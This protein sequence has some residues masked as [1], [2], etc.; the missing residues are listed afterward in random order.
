MKRLNLRFQQNLRLRILAQALYR[1]VIGPELRAMNQIQLLRILRQEVRRIDGSVSA[2]HDSDHLVLIHV[3]VAKLAVVNASVGILGFLRQRKLAPVHARSDDDGVGFIDALRRLNDLRR[4]LQAHALDRVEFIDDSAEI[5]RLLLHG[6][7]QILPRHLHEARIIL[8][9]RRIGDLSAHDAVFQYE[10]RQVHA[11]C[12]ECRRQTCDA[13]ADDDD[14]FMDS[15]F[16]HSMPL[17]SHVLS[18]QL[19][20]H[21][22]LYTKNIFFQ[23]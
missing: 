18:Q 13:C 5:L 4:R 11:P 3:P 2:A 1:D 21:V 9:P 8:D 12:I 19:R 22:L 17:L 20:L 16:F 15:L 7:D 10:H 23:I 6:L 14:I